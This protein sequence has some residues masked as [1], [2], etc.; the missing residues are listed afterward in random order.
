MPSLQELER[1]AIDVLR[2][3][4]GINEFKDASIAV[5]GGLAL[6]KYIPSGRT[7]EDV[8]FMINVHSA[9]DGVK[10]KLLKLPESRFVQHAQFFYYKSPSGQHIQIDIVPSWQ[11]S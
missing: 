2:I 1:A 8:D 10:Q 9:P 3:L 4:K 7:T 11:V 5:I 6:W